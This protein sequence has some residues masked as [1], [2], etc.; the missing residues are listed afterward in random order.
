MGEHATREEEV[1]DLLRR[2]VFVDLY[3]VV[4]QSMRISH[5][6]YSLKK[7]RQFFMPAPE[8]AR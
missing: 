8:R 7:V 3:Q 1:D 6:S 5:D 2:E 4:R